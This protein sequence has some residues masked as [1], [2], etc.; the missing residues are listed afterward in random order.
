MRRVSEETIGVILI[1]SLTCFLSSATLV[2][3][4]MMLAGFTLSSINSGNTDQIFLSVVSWS[5][6]L[7]GLVVLINIM[8]DGIKIIEKYAIRDEERY[9]RRNREEAGKGDDS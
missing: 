5:I 4:A 1:I 6:G 7:F 8:C 2:A 9:A 3:F